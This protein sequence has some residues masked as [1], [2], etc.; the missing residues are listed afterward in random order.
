MGTTS[1]TH[2][3]GGSDCPGCATPEQLEAKAQ[4][5]GA[6]TAV[7]TPSTTPGPA[8]SQPYPGFEGSPTTAAG[9]VAGLADRTSQT[10]GKKSYVQRYQEQKAAKGKAE[11]SSK[12]STYTGGVDYPTPSTLDGP[13]A[14]TTTKTQDQLIHE[15]AQ[16]E[17]QATDQAVRN[18]VVDVPLKESFAIS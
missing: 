10:G 15:A 12:P 2:A 4:A 16:A 5:D 18:S 9:S 14:G 17:V 3:P 6:I 1:E 13:A 8:A 11:A 7:A